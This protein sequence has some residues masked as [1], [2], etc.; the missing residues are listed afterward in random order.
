MRGRS[1]KEEGGTRRG[2][3]EGDGEEGDGGE[4]G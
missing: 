1:E 4:E 2:E 3:E